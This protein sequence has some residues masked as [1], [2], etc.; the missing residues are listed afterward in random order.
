ME[1]KQGRKHGR[2]RGEKGA[3]HDM[4]RMALLFL[5]I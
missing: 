1:L 4:C 2:K 5:K 3:G